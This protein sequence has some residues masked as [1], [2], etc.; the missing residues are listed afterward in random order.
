MLPILTKRELGKLDEIENIWISF[1]A[2]NG[3]ED[4]RINASL[5]FLRYAPQLAGTPRKNI[6]TR[7]RDYWDLCRWCAAKKVD[8]EYTLISFNDENLKAYEVYLKTELGNNQ[9]TAWVKMSHIRAVLKWVED[10]WVEKNFHNE[11]RGVARTWTYKVRGKPFQ[12]RSK[13]APTL[14]TVDPRRCLPYIEEVVVPKKEKR[15]RN[16]PYRKCFLYDL[17]GVP[18]T[19]TTEEIRDGFKKRLLV[20]HPDHGGSHDRS[21]AIKWALDILTDKRADYD[22][23]ISTTTG[24]DDIAQD[25][26]EIYQLFGGYKTLY[27][28]E[29]QG[30]L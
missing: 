22:A 15:K 8:D 21:V 7:L 12:K 23:Y 4:I 27:K 26:R 14:P 25:T 13:T 19:A 29:E 1:P 30:V 28:I 17:L 6:S 9:N 24:Y 11:K 10:R 3:G 5:L 16:P 20:T 2:K 18:M